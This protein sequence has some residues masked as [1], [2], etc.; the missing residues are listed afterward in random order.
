MRNVKYFLSP[1]AMDVEQKKLFPLAIWIRVGT[2]VGI[3]DCYSFSSSHIPL[4]CFKERS[5]SMAAL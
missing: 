4:F 2:Q 1:D 3:D 5:V